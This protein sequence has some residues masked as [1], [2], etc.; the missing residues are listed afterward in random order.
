MFGHGLSF[1]IDWL[2]QKRLD[3]RKNIAQKQQPE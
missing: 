1:F 2:L 3:P